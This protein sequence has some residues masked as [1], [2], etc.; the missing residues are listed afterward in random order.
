[1]QTQTSRT[2]NTTGRTS[3]AVMLGAKGNNVKKA[4]VKTTP[5]A[6]PAVKVTAA[7]PKSE[8][9]QEV[10]KPSSKKPVLEVAPVEV[11][12]TVVATPKPAKKATAK[13]NVK[14]KATITATSKDKKFHPFQKYGFH[15]HNEE[16]KGLV[17][18]DKVEFLI[19]KKV[20]VGEFVHFHVNNHSPKGYVVIKMNGKI[21]ERVLSKVSLA[22]T[23]AATE[24]KA[25]PAVKKV[26]VAK[27]K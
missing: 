26:P 4:I 5:K 17:K 1:M 3:P 12:P 13:T 16:I 22:S 9:R 2:G 24:P 7:L 25:A 6:A 14:E 21:Y 10:V 18:G 23:P 27:K 19:K 8:A 15:G 11:K 20:V